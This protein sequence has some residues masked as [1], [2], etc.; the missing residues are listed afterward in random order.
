MPLGNRKLKQ[1]KTRKVIKAFQEMQEMKQS[2]ANNLNQKNSQTKH[3]VKRNKI[4]EK[5]FEVFNNLTENRGSVNGNIKIR[6][7]LLESMC[8]ISKWID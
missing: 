2:S 4:K 3:L 6:W 5:M 8:A 1:T 7:P